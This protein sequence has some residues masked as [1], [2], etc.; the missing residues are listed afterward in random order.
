M[1]EFL[2]EQI[3][4]TFSG[5]NECG[6]MIG[7]I[8][9]T[10]A[11]NIFHSGNNRHQHVLHSSYRKRYDDALKLLINKKVTKYRSYPPP[12][13]NPGLIIH[14]LP[15]MLNYL[16]KWKTNPRRPFTEFIGITSGYFDLCIELLKYCGQIK[17]EI[18][19]D[20]VH[21]EIIQNCENT[22]VQMLKDYLVH[23]FSI[24][25]IEVETWGKGSV[26]KRKVKRRAADFG[27]EI[28]DWSFLYAKLFEAGIF[29]AIEDTFLNNLDI[30]TAADKYDDA[31]REQAEKIKLFLKSLLL[32]FNIT[33]QQKQKYIL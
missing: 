29:K 31:N 8:M 25:H 27:I 32:A 2:L 16:T 7:K 17:P 12:L 9:L 33:N 23:Q 4:N 19:G 1:F 13:V 5:Y 30:N 3:N 26:E 15:G 6:E 11:D 22:L 18:N 14:I 10:T 20:N 21:A 28:I 24:T